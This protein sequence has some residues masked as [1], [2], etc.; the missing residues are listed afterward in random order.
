M[1]F[2]AWPG[3]AAERP[4]F[5]P[6]AV[7]D[8]VAGHDE[9]WAEKKAAIS[10]NLYELDVRWIKLPET[11]GTG[12][13]LVIA[14][15]LVI[16]FLAHGH[17]VWLDVARRQGPYSTN[18]EVPM[19]LE[20][21]RQSGLIEN[22]K[23]NHAWFRVAGV[24]AERL[25]DRLRVYVAHHVF[26]DGCF[27]FQLSTLDLAFDPVEGLAQ[28]SDWKRLFR[29]EP[30]IAVDDASTK[31]FSGQQSGGRIVELDRDHL[32]VAYG[33]HEVDGYKSA[34]FPQDPTSPYGK[35]WRIAKD[36]T[37]A[38]IYAS[39]VRNPQG[40]F[41]DRRGRIW[42]TE[43]GP[44]GG[45]EL[46]RI[47]EGANYGWPF[48]TYGVFYGTKP[49]P[50]NPV[51][52]DHSAP[53]YVPPIFAWAPSIAPT[54]L[55]EAASGPFALWNGDLLIAT[56]RDES[57]RRLRVQGDR[58][59]YDERIALDYRIRDI[60]SLGSGDLVLFTDDGR[61]GLVSPAA[62]V[63]SASE[64]DDDAEPEPSAT[65][66]V[67][68]G[69]AGSGEKL[70]VRHCASC[71]SLT[72]AEGDVGPPLGGVVGREIGSAAGFT[73][74]PALRD[75]SGVWTEELL[76]A[77]SLEQA[78]SLP[79]RRCRRSSSLRGKCRTSRIT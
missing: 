78:R 46:N 1:A 7:R 77:S 48:Q 63:E 51:Q 55:V 10:S 27:Y 45:D 14:D 44:Q 16:V 74:S 42:E 49:W 26:E 36:G 62:L 9:P 67:A 39:G 50:L 19:N 65:P 34:N 79:A 66:V 41:K 31:P 5:R 43:H 8:F 61:V 28:A 47:V 69:E 29:P 17:V 75:A 23:V 4:V 54:N 2:S 15:D 57:V 56:L 37:S 12:G 60:A 24:H 58:I 13:G 22:A 11:S 32:L 21:L 20:E 64:T 25:S 53:G 52:G 70:F 40:L 35:I 6:D 68:E 18:I 72:L 76:A 59:A 3:S 38:A 33:D 71:H 30:C 73:Y